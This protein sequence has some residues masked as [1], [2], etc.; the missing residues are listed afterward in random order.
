MSEK[1]FAR[2]RVVFI[3]NYFCFQLTGG[4]KTNIRSPNLVISKSNFSH[5]SEGGILL[6]GDNAGIVEIENTDVRDSPENGLSTAFSHVNS[7]KL[8]NCQ[9]VRNKIGIKLS[10]FSGN[11][12]IENTKASNST[13]NGLYVD[14]NGEKTIHIEN[15][16]VFH[17]NGYGL[18]LDGS[19]TKVKLSAT[20]IFF[21]WNKASSVYSR[22]YYG[23]NSPCSSHTSFI[24]CTFYANRGPVIDIDLSPHSNPWQFDG[25]L[26]LNNTQGPVILTTRYTNRYYTPELFVRNNSFLFNFCQDKSVIDIIGGTKVLIVEGNI[27]KQN[28]GRS[29]YIEKTSPSGATIR[30]N[31]FTNNSCLN[32]GVIEIQ[33]IGKD[34]AIVDNILKSNKGQF[35]VLLQCEYV[36]GVNTGIKNVTFLNNSLLNNVAVSSSSPTCQLKVSGFAEW[37]PFFISFNRFGS[38]DFSKELCVSTQ[39]SSHSSTMQASLNV[40]GYDDEEKV[41]ERIFDGEDNYEKTFVVFRPYISNAGN[42]IKGSQENTTFNALSKSFLGGRILSNVLLRKEKSPYTVVSDVT[43]LPEAS[44][45]IDPGVEVQFMPGV[46]MLVLGSLFVGGNVHQPVKFS[47]SKVTKDDDF[48][49][50]R[51]AGGKFPWEGRVQILHN[52]NWTSLCFNETQGNKTNDVKLI[53][54]RLGYQAPLSVNH[55]HHE[56]SGPW[57]ACA[58]L[59][60]KGSELDLAECSISFQSLSCNTSC[61]LVLNC[62]EGRPWGNIRFLR[63]ARNTSNLSTSSLK[64]LRIEHCGEKHGQNVAAIEMIQYVPEVNH[65]TVLNCTSG[66]MKVL[67]PEK[68]VIIMNSSFVNTGGNGTDFISTKNNVTLKNVKSIKNEFGLSFHEA[69]GDWFNTISYGKV[70]LCSPQKVVNV[71]DHDVFVYFRAPFV[72]FSDLGVSCQIKVQTEASAGFAIQLLLL[73]N[74]RSFRIEL[75][76]RREIF[77]TYG[78]SLGLLLKRNLIRWD[79]FT[80]HFEGRYSS[81]MLLQVQRVDIKG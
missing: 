24:N 42:I 36:V 5:N 27:F 78:S 40:W 48:L 66:G 59:Q 60:C 52:W 21:G 54:E 57:D 55:S 51:L 64:H 39:D 44:L 35:M 23:C 41:K 16:G 81:E 68:E 9:F 45:S 53:C 31:V 8:L 1:S 73:K 72:S 6:G 30:S 49:K 37:R 67:F 17:S 33:R 76:N 62:G 70:N 3:N 77:R 22:S 13:E 74:V 32:C 11:V 2:L 14:T 75:P 25:N 65:V 26:F 7:L 47:L 10:S 80:V 43:I 58:A 34:I 20:K 71:T 28:S 46:G 69:Y 61:H 15:G 19:Y 63:E 56:S 4:G 29:V 50:I 38:Q 79:S 12:N 18:F